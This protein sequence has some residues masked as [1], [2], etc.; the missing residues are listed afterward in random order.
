MPD[1]FATFEMKIRPWLDPSLVQQ[2]FVSLAAKSH[3][4]SNREPGAHANFQSV[5]AAH[6]ILRDPVRRLEAALELES[7]GILDAAD[8]HLVPTNLPDLFMSIATLHRQISA[9]CGQR[10]LSHEQPALSQGSHAR[11]HPAGVQGRESRSVSTSPLSSALLRSETFTLRSDLEHLTQKVNQQWERCENQ[12]RAVDA[13]WERRTPEML[14]H[15]ASVY[16][17][18]SYLQRWKSQLK[19]ADLLL[20]TCA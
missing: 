3:P 18:M 9:F 15:L 8:G 19:E 6:Q 20:K 16:R 14:R 17:E 11:S 12:V 4:D 5:T 1:P 13:V 10:A 7:P 2:K